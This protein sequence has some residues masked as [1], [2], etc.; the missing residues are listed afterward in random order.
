MDNT[1]T[2]TPSCKW[3]LSKFF[4]GKAKAKE[5]PAPVKGSI[6]CRT[7]ETTCHTIKSAISLL[8]FV[9]TPHPAYNDPVVLEVAQQL[10][11][12]DRE[13]NELQAMLDSALKR[14]E[15]LKEIYDSTYIGVKSNYTEFMKR[16]ALTECSSS[17]SLMTVLP[18]DLLA[19]LFTFLDPAACVNLSLVC[20]NWG[21][22]MASSMILWK[23]WSESYITL[24]TSGTSRRNKDKQH[25]KKQLRVD[26]QQQFMDMRKS[27]ERWR[28]GRPSSTVNVRSAHDRAINHMFLDGGYLYTAGVATH[29]VKKWDIDTMECVECFSVSGYRPL[30]CELEMCEG[31]VA[32][33]NNIAMGVMSVCKMGSSSP[34]Y[35]INEYFD[36]FDA[37]DGC[38]LAHTSSRSQVQTYD[39]F[40]GTFVRAYEHQEGVRCLSLYGT[41]FVSAVEN[42]VL[43]WDTRTGECQQSFEYKRA[44][45]L[46]LDDERVVAL[47]RSFRSDASVIDLRMIQDNAEMHIVGHTPNYECVYLE[48][49]KLAFGMC[50]Q[51]VDVWDLR[52]IRDVFEESSS[53]TSSVE[54][55]DRVTS[56]YTYKSKMFCGLKSGDLQVF[57]F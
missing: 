26:Y 36:M 44:N 38:I 10:H 30:F 54:T 43:L 25:P 46:I 45:R 22:I 15:Q 14:K 47:R 1:R 8:G 53:P 27:E 33:V 34:G 6:F 7:A 18:S 57:D 3:S 9:G 55:R 42:A 29:D 16:H 41:T 5:N 50:K 19:Y 40:T 20:K 4:C 48:R 51:A 39:L 35:E 17:I 32:V 49:N 31:E 28:G 52:Q 13:C 56:I 21:K 24:F 2:T 23:V 11:D 12:S 37:A